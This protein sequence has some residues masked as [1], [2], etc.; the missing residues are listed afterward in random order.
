[1]I[2]NIFITFSFSLKLLEQALCLFFH[3]RLLFFPELLYFLNYLISF[4]HTIFH[5]LLF[6]YNILN[7]GIK[8]FGSATKLIC[9]KTQIKKLLFF[10]KLTQKF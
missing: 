10:F 9:N 3:F 4:N 2:I 8:H 7:I 6:L 1:V 5:Y